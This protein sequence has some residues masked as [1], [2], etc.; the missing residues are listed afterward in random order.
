L[1]ELV[2][3]ECILQGLYGTLSYCKEMVGQLQ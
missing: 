1:K 3:Y 2:G